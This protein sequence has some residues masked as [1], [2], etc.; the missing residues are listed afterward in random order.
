MGIVAVL[1]DITG[2]KQA[3]EAMK[4]TDR[5]LRIF[6]EHSPAA[7]AMFDRDMKYIVASRRF[8]RDYDLGDQN[9][10][11]RS[12][13]EVFPEIPYRW[14]EIHRRC[15]AGAVEKSEEDPFPRADGS[16]DW[17]R[18]EIH[19]W[20]ETEGEIG[21]VIL[22]SEVLTERKQAEEELR[23]HRD[24][25]EELVGE[26]TALLTAKTDELKEKQAALLNLV[27]DLNWKSEELAIARERAEAAD[28]IKSA[29]LA[30]MS[31]ELRTPL[32]S[33]IGF[34]GILLQSLVGPLNEEQHKQLKMVQDSAHHLLALINDVLDISKIEAGHVEIFAE[35]FDMPTLLRKIMEKFTP[36]TE[37]KGVALTARI[38]PEV[39]AIVSDR[40][41]VE[42][43]IINLLGNAVKFTGQGEVRLECAIRGGEED[44]RMVICVT[45]TGGGMKREELEAIFKPFQQID[46]GI[47]RQ[48]EGT[49]LGLSI[50]K[51]LV[52]MLGGTIGVES[53]WGK[54]SIFTFALPL[55]KE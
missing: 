41:R 16:M 42:Q 13:Y 44:G 12:H 15:L 32:N 36:L 33:I 48:Y 50:C 47:T 46:N 10:I 34:T 27:E 1:E 53:E 28:R 55:Q 24:H 29:F 43:I 5:V 35:R 25:L 7:L 6:V 20:Y 31:H 51:R 4:R 23:R 9:I 40:R 11:G 19:P 18:W 22:F 49:G 26:R 17:V 45:D 54:G 3:E 8:L 30:T 2:R 52:E 14:R 39:G 21:G 38:A 37:K